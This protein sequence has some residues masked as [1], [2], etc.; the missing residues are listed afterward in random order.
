MRCTVEEVGVAEGDVSGASCDEVVDVGYN[1]LGLDDAKEPVIYGGKGTLATAVPSSMSRLDVTHLTMLAV[2]AEVRVRTE[3]WQ[4]RSVG[5]EETLS[6]DVDRDAGQMAAAGSERLDPGQQLLFVLPNDHAIYAIDSP[7][8][9]IEPV[10]GDR[11]PGSRGPHALDGSLG[12][13]HSGV[14]RHRDRDRLDRL[15][16][17]SIERR[18]GEVERDRFVAGRGETR[19]RRCHVERLMTELIGG[20]EQNAHAASVLPVRVHATTSCL[21]IVSECR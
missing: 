13:S 12:E 9:G 14:H 16:R 5:D 18:N 2:S 11:E 21:S 20:D 3:R 1:G 6:P 17:L 4:P 8:V 10:N 19:S 7:H 15:E